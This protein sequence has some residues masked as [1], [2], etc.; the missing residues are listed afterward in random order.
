MCAVVVYLGTQYVPPG[1]VT[2]AAT[3]KISGYVYTGGTPL[4]GVDITLDG[5]SD[6]TDANGYYEFTGLEGNKSYSLATSKSGYESSSVAVQ[7]GTQDKQ[8]EDITLKTAEITLPLAAIKSALATQ[9]GVSTDN[10]ELY[11]TVQAAQTDNYATGAV[12]NRQKSMVIF[13]LE[14]TA[15]I[16]IVDNYTAETPDEQAAMENLAEK[17]ILSRYSHG[18]RIVPFNIVKQDSTYTFDYYD[19]YDMWLKRWG[20]GTAVIDENGDVPE[21]NMIHSWI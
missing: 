17:Q 2:P 13:Y 16:T 8:A 18:Y 4:S 9:E 12:I 21:E 14:S 5:Q 11:F 15:G 20:F 1:V 6:T 3:Y 19:D 7:L 10:V